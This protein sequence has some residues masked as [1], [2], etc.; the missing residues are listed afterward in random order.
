MNIN[1]LEIE[2]NKLTSNE[3]IITAIVDDFNSYEASVYIETTKHCKKRSVAA[4][5]KRFFKETFNAK[6]YISY[7]EQYNGYFFDFMYDSYE[8]QIKQVDA[9]KSDTLIF[10]A[11]LEEFGYDLT[12]KDFSETVLRTSMIANSTENH[13]ELIEEEFPGYS[14]VQLYTFEHG[15]YPSIQFERDTTYYG[16]DSDGRT[17]GAY[18]TDY[19]DLVETVKE[20]NN[21]IHGYEDDVA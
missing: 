16:F 20:I 8:K 7:D 12:D 13:I 11:K 15:G 10:S 1:T 4:Y 14:V 21:S 3:E 5:I 19:S 18:K 9:S 2:L 17:F 6:V